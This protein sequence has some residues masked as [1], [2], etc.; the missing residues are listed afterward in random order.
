MRIRPRSYHLGQ[1]LPETELFEKKSPKHFG[2]SQNFQ[3][4]KNFQ[5]LSKK[6]KDF[7]VFL[8][9]IRKKIGFSKFSFFLNFLK[10]FE[11][12]IKNLRTKIRRLKINIF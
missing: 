2:K 8:K 3:I 11:K 5:N 10:F 4:F 12:K 1:E 9:K 6:N 7:D